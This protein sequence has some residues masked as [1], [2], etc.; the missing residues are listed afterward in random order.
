M[1]PP[2][3]RC[4]C[5]LVLLSPLTSCWLSFVRYAQKGL[6]TA[7]AYIYWLVMTSTAKTIRS[8]TKVITLALLLYISAIPS[9]PLQSMASPLVVR[10]L[11]YLSNY[12]LDNR[13]FSSSVIESILI[14]S[15]Y[16]ICCNVQHYRQSNKS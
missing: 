11:H 7:I 2:N 5:A 8:T 4:H 12:Y 6:N 9:S 3:Y 10:L 15:K 14:S 13:R 16:T 1:V